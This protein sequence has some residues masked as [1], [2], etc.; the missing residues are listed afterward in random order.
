MYGTGQTR[1]IFPSPTKLFTPGVTTLIALLITG[2][3][4]S[5]F[6]PGFTSGF[7]A[8]TARNIMRG[9]I[10]QLV[11]YPFVS[12]SSMNV[13]FGG[14]MV[15]FI[16]SA[17]ER[18]WRTASFLL[19]WL[20]VSVGCGLIWVIVNLL[21]GNNIVGM[22]ASACTYGLLATMGLLFR[23]RRFFM[24]FATVESRHL[25][26]ILIAI[27]ILMNIRSPINLVW[28]SGALVAYV[29]IKLRWRMASQSHGSVPSVGQRR[30]GSFVDVD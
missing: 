3:L 22:G 16:G 7:L 27:G 25:V 21:T 17:I 19:L 29:Y 4:L 30:S 28:I 20:V 9:K 5:T 15:L 26:L 12:S 6:A 8:L 13:V 1:I 11:T 2:M 24:F 10:W 14:L 18:E 23:G